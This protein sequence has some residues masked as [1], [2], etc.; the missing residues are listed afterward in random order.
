MRFLSAALVFFMLV[1]PLPVLAADQNDLLRKIEELSRELDKVKQQLTDMQKKDDAAEQRLAKTEKDVK[2][3]KSSKRPSGWP[4]WLELSGGYRFRFDSLKGNSDAYLQYDRDGSLPMFSPAVMNAL[5][6]RHADLLPKF[7]PLMSAGL[8]PT[9]LLSPV[10]G[11]TAKNDAVF[12]NRFHL[13]LKAKA[14]EDITFKGRLLMYKAWGNDFAD[15]DQYFADRFVIMDGNIG[16]VPSDNIL[17]VD[18]AYA[19]WSNIAGLPVWFSVGRR[20]S[21]G[22]VPTN[23]RQNIERSGSSGVPGLLVDYAFDGLTLGVAPDI[24]ALP[25]AYAKFCYG[26][27]LDTG[28]RTDK[29][30]DDRMKDVQFVG[31]NLVPYDTDNLHLE[32]QWQRGTSI[33]AFP[34]N[35]DPFGLGNSNRNIGD[36]D[37]LGAVVT[38]RIEKLGIGDLNLF[39]TAALS[40]T[41]PNG[42]GYEA[43][44]IY[45]ANSGATLVSA[46]F[47]LLYDNPQFGGRQEDHSGSAVYLGARY[48]IEKTGTKIGLEYNHGSKYWMAFTPAS[49]DLWT[50]KLATRGDVFEGYVIQ[51][52]RNTPI[53]K[54]GKAFVRLG[55][56]NYNFKYTGS[57][58]WLGEPKKISDLDRNDPLDSQMFA[59]IKRAH[60]IYLTFDVLF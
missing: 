34:G 49:D 43:P 47:G 52:I 21:T 22:G 11:F 37:W 32:L 14:T 28:F 45:D 5:M 9:L 10:D 59:P 36:I 3:V 17:R 40:K 50:S 15:Q 7:A 6:T 19:T 46:K 20:P 1:L 2:D 55:Y 13:D 56:Q 44:F 38:G 4:S 27:G 30:D 29:E 12:F 58:F 18:Q 51:E 54:F 48:D 8:A 35:S 60:D 57:G 41:H 23:I 24:A 26:K 33:F 16:H 39:A 31:V 42:K 25:G 53:S